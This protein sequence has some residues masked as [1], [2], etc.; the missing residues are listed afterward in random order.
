MGRSTGA[1]FLLLC[2]ACAALAAE[3]PSSFVD[4]AT[5]VPGLR[6]DMRY[7]TAN[8][9]IGKLIAGYHAPKCYLTKR[10]AEALRRVQEELNMQRLGLK[11]YDCYR[12]QSAVNAFVRW[13]RNL[14]D[15][16]MKARFYPNV[17]KRDLFRSG[18]IASRSG[19]SRGSTVDLTVVPLTAAKQPSYDPSAPLISCEWPKAERAP[20]N[21][22]DMGTGFDCFSRR[23]HTAYSG[24]GAEQRTNRRI[25]TSAMARQGFRNLKTEWWHF[26]LRNEPYPNTYFDFPVE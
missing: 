3:R 12:P 11:V 20:D 22:L 5:V 17:R 21:S 2:S 19:H 14:A 24:I 8:N 9:F 7:A 10:A 15:T 4:A 16:K 1:T 6:I 23:S 13:G 18:Y 26:T 25:L